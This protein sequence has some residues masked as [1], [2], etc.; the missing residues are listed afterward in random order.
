MCASPPELQLP[1]KVLFRTTN[2]HS[3]KERIETEMYGDEKCRKES[4]AKKQPANKN[5]VA[6][7][8]S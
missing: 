8:R 6:D 3:G 4:S 7:N 1:F 2:L 5:C